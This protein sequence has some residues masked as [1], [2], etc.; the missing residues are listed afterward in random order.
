[1]F[2]LIL[3]TEIKNILRDRLYLFFVLYPIVF[4]TGGYFL[5]NWIKDTYPSSPWSAITAMMLI[6]VTGFIFGA[7][8]AFTLLDDKDDKVLI[9]LK[10]TPISV[11]YYVYAKLLIGMIFGFVASFI[12]I[13]TTNFLPNANIF[14]ILFVS[15]LAAVQVPSVAL[16]V[17]SFSSNK[18]EG[19]VIM[20]LSGM[21]ILFPLIGFLVS[22]W[23]QYLLGIAPGYWAGRLIEIKLLPT[24]HG[25]PILIF[26][27]GLSY[28]ICAT[29][30]L[31]KLFT[32]KS[33]L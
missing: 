32:K 28:N 23:T 6:V 12:L 9:S 4:G 20:K 14:V 30:L 2:K 22:G 33:N 27:I 11:K 13:L 3:K 25:S 19:F 7:L 15:I 26:L 31:M 21:I 16:I 18:V 5:V 17:N 8:I 29:W 10:I 1:M 24:E